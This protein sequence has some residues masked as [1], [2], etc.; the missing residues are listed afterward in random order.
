MAG[1]PE[2]NML[3]RESIKSPG[4]IAFSVVSLLFVLYHAWTAFTSFGTLLYFRVGKTATP[5]SA[6]NGTMMI[7]WAVV[8][9]VIAFIL[10]SPRVGT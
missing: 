10:V 9:L 4:W 8:S 6:L 5:S 3:W 1:G 7:A 2:A